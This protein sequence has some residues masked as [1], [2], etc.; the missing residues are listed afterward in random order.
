MGVTHGLPLLEVRTKDVSDVRPTQ[1]VL[2]RVVP[3][4]SNTVSTL[5]VQHSKIHLLHQGFWMSEKFNRKIVFHKTLQNVEL[6][7]FGPSKRQKSIFSLLRYFVVK[8]F[9]SLSA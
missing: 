2:H 4:G 9:P 7:P 3:Q 6:K 5:M 1:S 8:V